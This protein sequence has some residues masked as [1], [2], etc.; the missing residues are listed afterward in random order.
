MFY[1]LRNSRFDQSVSLGAIQLLR[2]QCGGKGDLRKRKQR[3]TGGGGVLG[4]NI[5]IL[6]DFNDV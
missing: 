1:N 3:P 4:Q 2:S 5:C 6:K